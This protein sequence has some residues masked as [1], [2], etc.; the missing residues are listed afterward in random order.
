ME[1]TKR[2][3]IGLVPLVDYQRASYW[4]LPGYMQGIEQAGGVPVMLPERSNTSAISVGLVTMS[5]AAVRA[6]VTFREPSQSIRS[7]LRTLL[8][9]VIPIGLPPS[10]AMPHHSLCGCG[11]M[12]YEA[13]PE[14]RERIERK[15]GGIDFPER[16]AAF[17]RYEHRRAAQQ[18]F[19]S[20][21][22]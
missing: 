2:P 20:A 18:S 10:E 22:N 13:S 12:W 9:F 5:G 19:G 14:E 7:A 1:T 3:L 15:A 4:M 17:N 8:E 6:K 11:G 21:L 16:G